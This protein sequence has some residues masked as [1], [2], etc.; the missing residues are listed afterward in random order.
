MVPPAC[1][2][3]SRRSAFTLIELLVVISIIALLIGILLPA[4]GAARNTARDAGC[5]SNLRQVGLAVAVYAEDNSEYNVPYRDVWNSDPIYWSAR[6]IDEG[7]F[8]AG[9]AF[10]CPR[11]EEEGFDAWTPDSIDEGDQNGTAA[12]Q[13][14]WLR[15]SDWLHIHYGM[16]TSNVG[17]IQRRTRFGATRPYVLDVGGPNETTLTPRTGDF[18]APSETAYVM[19]AA[20]ATD[21]AGP[22]LFAGFPFDPSSVPDTQST[23]YRGIN[24][25]WDYNGGG[26]FA[27]PH[28]RHSGNAFNVCYVDGHVSALAVGG[29][30]SLSTRMVNLAYTEEFLGNASFQDTPNAW[31]ETGQYTNGAGYSPP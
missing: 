26:I 13:D 19:D 2:R 8:G 7:Y 20:T 31:T 23:S 27:H 22:S 14:Q 24:F 5:L 10:I 30:N 12:Q 18:R 16:N 25:V 1:F 17:T 9:D 29:S 28:A 15:D 3:S 6:L 11:M 21:I 4:L